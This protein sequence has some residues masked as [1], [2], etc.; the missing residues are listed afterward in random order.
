MS[1]H[2]KS[3]AAIAV[4]LYL[5]F[6]EEILSGKCTQIERLYIDSSD[7]EYQDAEIFCLIKGDV[8]GIQNFIYN[9]DMD[10][11]VK[12]LKARSFYISYLTEIVAR[13]IVDEENLTTSN[14]LYCGGGHFYILAPAKSEKNLER[15]REKIQKVMLQAHGL[16]LTVLLSSVTFSAA[17]LDE[18]NF[19]EILHKVG[20]KIS[21]EKLRKF[22]SIM[23]NDFFVPKDNTNICPYCKKRGFGR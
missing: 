20:Q 12:N 9:I 15:Y 17:E 14:I 5:Q 13:Y 10:D 7:K 19:P 1:S 23:S 21:E 8:S 22:K 6:Q 4:C 16:D 2:L 11:A 18:G 3:T